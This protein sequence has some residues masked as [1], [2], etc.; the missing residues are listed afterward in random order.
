MNLLDKFTSYLTVY[1]D[2]YRNRYDLEQSVAVTS[3]FLVN[4]GR[5][6]IEISSTEPTPVL[7]KLW[8]NGTELK[9]TIDTDAT[10][11]DKYLVVV[12]E[13][14]ASGT[15]LYEDI[16]TTNI[17]HLDEFIDPNLPLSEQ[18]T[19]APQALGSLLVNTGI[20]YTDFPRGGDG[21]SI[22]ADST[23]LYGLRWQASG[24]DEGDITYRGEWNSVAAY[25]NGDVVKYDG[26][27]YISIGS[28]SD[29]EP[30]N[31]S[32]WEDFVG[33]GSPGLPGPQGQKGDKGDPGLVWSGPWTAREYQVGETVEVSG[34]SYIA[35]TVTTQTPPGIDWDLVSGGLGSFLVQSFTVSGAGTVQAGRVVIINDSGT[36][37]YADSTV[38]DHRHRVVGITL[39][40]GVTS[41]TVSVVLS[42]I[43][44]GDVI[45]PGSP[46]WNWIIGLPIFLGSNGMLTQESEQLG[47]TRVFQIIVGTPVATNAI[48]VM[49]HP[50]YIV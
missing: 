10:G 4:N 43:L 1:A 19:Y 23:S 40:T 44:D 5:M 35:T 45:V 33:K 48:R 18:P 2:L 39:Q 30:P 16:F 3:F 34:S 46:I 9:K 42:G 12:M 7:D 25:R 41:D 6:E 47:V 28:N 32:Y 14:T 8:W 20:E 24:S 38:L 21:Q 17:V 29:K 22:V 13:G 31:L 11:D 37:E 49:F 27:T 15:T 36:V 50:P 26:S